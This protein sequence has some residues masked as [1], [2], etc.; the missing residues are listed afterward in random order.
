MRIRKAI[1]LIILL[2]LFGAFVF[3]AGCE[4]KATTPELE[5]MGSEFE[6]LNETEEINNLTFDLNESEL[7]ELED[8]F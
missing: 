3:G 5:S 4:K 1:V 7:S 8:L 2:L 6:K